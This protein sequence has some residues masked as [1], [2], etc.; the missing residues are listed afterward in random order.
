MLQMY[1]DN[2]F[3]L[4]HFQGLEPIPAGYEYKDEEKYKSSV[5]ILKSLCFIIYSKWS[6]RQLS[7]AY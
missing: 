2:I 5:E 6:C 4:V 7:S 1:Q 3:R